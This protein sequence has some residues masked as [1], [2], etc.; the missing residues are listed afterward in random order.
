VD[1]TRLSPSDSTPSASGGA[2]G[3]ITTFW[4]T[5]DGFRRNLVRLLV[6]V[7]LLSELRRTGAAD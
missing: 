2:P 5:V 7:L 1:N 6:K 4:T 3:S